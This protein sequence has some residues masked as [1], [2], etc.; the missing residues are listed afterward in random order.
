MKSIEHLGPGDGLLVACSDEEPSLE[1][2]IA[3]IPPVKGPPFKVPFLDK[4]TA[5]KQ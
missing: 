5:D 1:M 3:N 4:I 2:D